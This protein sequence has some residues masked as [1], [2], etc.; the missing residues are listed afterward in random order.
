MAR[1]LITVAQA[2]TGL[3]ARTPAQLLA[4]V[5]DSTS[6]RSPGRWWRPPRSAPRCPPLGTPRRCLR[7]HR[8]AHGPGR[9]RAPALPARRPQSLS[10]ERLSGTAAPLGWWQSTRNKVAMP[11]SRRIRRSDDGAQEPD[12]DAAAGRPAGAGRGRPT[13]TVSVA[14]DV[15]VA[16]TP[17]M[18]SISRPGRQVAD[19]P[20]PD[21]HRRQRRVPLRLQVFAA[22]EPPTFQA[23]TP[24]RSSPRRRPSS[25]SPRRPGATV[26][27]VNRAGLAAAPGDGVRN[28][29]A[30]RMSARSDPLADRARTAVFSR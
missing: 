10:V 28:G 11:R 7:C 18:R 12:R 2:A 25:A 26:T 23:Y 4:E 15:T 13:T 21:R 8:V 22:R 1:S 6:R 14:S 3:P 27:Q 20:G 29:Q 16:G 9:I 30:S 19:R 5:A 24:S 17:P